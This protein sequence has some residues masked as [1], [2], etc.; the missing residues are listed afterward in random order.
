MLK[1][2]I[3][4]IREIKIFVLI[5]NNCDYN[6]IAGGS[7]VCHIEGYVICSHMSWFVNEAKKTYTEHMIQ[8][9]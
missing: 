5:L 3:K 6:I 7:K 4:I 8:F 2:L 1:Y 9:L